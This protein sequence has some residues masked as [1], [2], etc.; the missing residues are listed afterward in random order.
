MGTIIKMGCE[1]RSECIAKD[2]DC[3]FGERRFCKLRDMVLDQ[4]KQ[5]EY[6]LKELLSKQEEDYKLQMEVQRWKV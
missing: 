1:Y 4:R 2:L 6:E 3:F 5:K